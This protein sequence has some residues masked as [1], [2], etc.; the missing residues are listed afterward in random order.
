VGPVG[1]VGPVAASDGIKKNAPTEDDEQHISKTKTA[2][3]L[4]SII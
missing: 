3:T 4:G 1:P 2:I